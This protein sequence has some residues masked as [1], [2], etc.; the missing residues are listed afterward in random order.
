MMFRQHLLAVRGSASSL[1]SP[2]RRLIG[3]LSRFGRMVRRPVNLLT[4]G[5]FVAAAAAA[6]RLNGPLQPAPRQPFAP[7]LQKGSLPFVRASANAFGVSGAV[8]VRF[9]LPGQAL[10]YPL[11]VEGDP[12]TLSYVW[13][14]MGDRSIATQPQP[15]AGAELTAPHQPGFYRMVLV[16]GDSQRVLEDLAVAVLIPFDNTVGGMLNGYRLGTYLSERLGTRSTPV[17]FL[18]IMPRDL[19]LKVT[20]H[21]RVGDFLSHDRQQTWPRYAAV[22]PKLLDKVELVVAEVSRWHGSDSLRLS[23]AVKSG[24]RSPEHNQHIRSAA[25][26]SR[27]QYGDAADIAIDANG[28]GRFTEVDSRLVG[29]AVEIVELRYPELAGGLGLYL[30]SNTPFVH[31]DARGKRVR[32]RG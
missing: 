19:D 24:F 17:G 14:R 30:D 31:I 4:L 1:A 25:R 21:L 23:V 10:E 28:D 27:H 26:D 15:L 8:K 2:M 20:K 5:L 6:M 7:F 32:W 13:A 12:S 11:A 16:Q 3:P 29:L 9:A 18:E 22:S